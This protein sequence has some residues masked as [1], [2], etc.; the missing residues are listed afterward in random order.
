MIQFDIT[1]HHYASQLHKINFLNFFNYIEA[2]YLKKKN[3]FYLLINQ[4]IN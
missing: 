1:M 3:I 4:H 2:G